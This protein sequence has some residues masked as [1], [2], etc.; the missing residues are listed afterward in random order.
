MS[1]PK[2]ITDHKCGKID[3]LY[4]KNLSER[5]IAKNINRAKTLFHN[6]F[7]ER[8]GGVFKKTRGHKKIINKR[9]Q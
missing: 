1:K 4:S 5:E 9:A 7:K 8:N 6:Y 2:D 3:A